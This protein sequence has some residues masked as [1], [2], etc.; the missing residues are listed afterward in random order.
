MKLIE[1]NTYDFPE[2]AC[3]NVIYVD[4]TAYMH[5]LITDENQKLN[6]ISRPRR[7]GKSLMIST[8]KAIFQGRRELF[9]GLAIDKLD[10][11]WQVHPIIHFDM[12]LIS[13]EDMDVFENDFAATVATALKAS[14]YEYKKEFTPGKNFNDAI[15][16]L[17]QKTGKGVVILVDEYDAPVGHSL[18]DIDRA[19]KIRAALS[20][21]YIQIK[22]NVG[23]VRFLM[24]TGVSK[25]TQLTVFSALNNLTDLTFDDRY[26]AMLG[27]TEE[28][29]DEY[30]TE[31]MQKHAEK[32]DKSYEDY[33]MALKFWCNGYRFT[34]GNAVSVYNP[35]A[36]GMTLHRCES[37]F[38][39]SWSGTGRSSSLMNHI[40][41]HEIA[42][43][44]YENLTNV[45]ESAF[46]VC[47]LED[48][49]TIG[50]LY[51]S[52][53]LTIKDY[54]IYRRSYT[55]GVP[56]QEIRE[57][58]TKLI[59][60]SQKGEREGESFVN[61]ISNGL[62]DKNYD[63]VE[64][65]LRAY[66][67]DLTYGSREK[68]GEA[69]YQRILHTLLAA[70]GFDVTSE[71]QQA[72]GRADIV[73]KHPLGVYVFELKVDESAEAAIAQIKE[74][75]YCI[76]YFNTKSSI[77]NSPSNGGNIPVYAV[78]INFNSKTR[79]VDGFIVVPQCD[80]SL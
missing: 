9:S 29:L 26:A 17:A 35:V 80:N 69:S 27:Y 13:T 48:I 72:I 24:M 42:E 74:K 19:Q 68:V 63:L 47:G 46:D 79:N 7:F 22:G 36:I 78:G 20:A 45:K 65:A 34:R 39:K 6:F 30:F 71:K 43:L 33:R 77:L 57:D 59:V 50:L 5:K 40:K 21:L 54:D 18:D 44:D 64:E 55:L 25:F 61:D 53:Y 52:G 51:Q 67:A 32:M 76:P 28:E 3:K 31:H 56:N 75:G 38:S 16:E 62:F 23:N 11:D 60:Y 15:Q 70:G 2:I 58:L 49:S 73:A 66:Y 37:F 14:G 8:L 1:Q 12:S 41:K 4:K 10:Y